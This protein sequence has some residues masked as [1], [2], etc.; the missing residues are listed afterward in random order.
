MGV[1]NWKEKEDSQEK[2]ESGANH[3]KA[4]SRYQLRRAYLWSIRNSRQVIID[5]HAVMFGKFEEQPNL[6]A[7]LGT[8][9]KS[10]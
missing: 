9:V 3:D 6:K 10:C 5:R 4:A 2:N 7:L 1:S 8:I